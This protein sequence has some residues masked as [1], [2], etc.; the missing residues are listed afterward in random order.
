MRYNLW[1]LQ[2]LLRKILQFNYFISFVVSEAEKPIAI[3]WHYNTVSTK[4]NVMRDIVHASGG[5]R[6]EQCICQRCQCININNECYWTM[7]DMQMKIKSVKN[8]AD[9]HMYICIVC[10]HMW[11]EWY[12][13]RNDACIINNKWNKL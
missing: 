4:T 8:N 6:R 3:L 13:K 1:M 5:E 12:W 11:H 2:F 9:T 10:V 7:G